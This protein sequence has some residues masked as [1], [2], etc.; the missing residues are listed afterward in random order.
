MITLG[1]ETSGREGSV[2][3]VSDGAL[4][5]ERD[6][7]K[8]GR[9][10]ARTLVAKVRDL[11]VEQRLEPS[12][13]SAVAV[14]IGPG[15]FTGL[16]VGVT[17]VKT[18]AYATKCAVVAVD[19]FQAIAEQ[20]SAPDGEILVISDAQRHE[21]F[22]GRFQPYEGQGCRSLDEVRIVSANDIAAMLGPETLLSG[23]AVDQVGG[24]LLDQSRIVST[25]NRFPRS[26]TI[27]RIGERL[28]RDGQPGDVWRIEPQ[29][30]RRSA[31]E[32][33]AAA[34]GVS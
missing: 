17:F 14:S 4:L 21:F 29:Y 22:A 5:G 19:T 6:L 25:P 24:E 7:S 16:R 30:L 26:E 3:L 31:A 11:L 27:A 13:V 12:Q 34:S 15:S 28:V 9:R 8:E 2:A 1:V 33:K 32:E 10:H 23:P 20:A 18:W